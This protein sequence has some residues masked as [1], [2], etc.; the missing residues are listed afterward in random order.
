MHVYT[1]THT[2]TH[3][4]EMGSLSSYSMVDLETWHPGSKMAHQVKLSAAKL[5]DLCSIPEAHTMEGESQLLKLSFAHTP[6]L[7]VHRQHMQVCVCMH[8][9]IHAPNLI[10]V[11]ITLLKK[12]YDLQPLIKMY[13]FR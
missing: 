2:V 9:H 6:A 1:N 5:E 10:K 11:L 13:C 4:Q 8:T 3:T 7:L 12:K